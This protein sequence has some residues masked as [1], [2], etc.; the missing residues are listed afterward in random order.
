MK[1]ITDKLNVLTKREYI[2]ISLIAIFLVFISSDFILN[3]FFQEIT[4]SVL[5]VIIKAILIALLLVAIAY[6]VNIRYIYLI[7]ET[8][9]NYYSTN[10]KYKKILQKIKYDYLFYKHTKDEMFVEISD[11]IQT[12]LGYN[13]QEFIISLKHH[14]INDLTEGVFKK[15]EP[16]VKENIIVP[17]YE[18]D[19]YAKNGD[20]HR[21][22]IYET[23]IL[24]EKGEVESIDVVAHN[25]HSDNMSFLS[26][27]ESTYKKI[28]E[29][30]NSAILIIKDNKFIESNSK[31][32]EIYDCSIEEIT[33]ASPFSDRFSPQ[34]QPDGE[35]SEEKANKYIQQ[36]LDI[37]YVEFEWIHFKKN[38]KEFLSEISLTTFVYKL[39]KYLL[40]TV[41]EKNL[42]DSISQSVKNK[43]EEIIKIFENID[44]AFIIINKDREILF[45]NNKLHYNKKLDKNVK[46]INQLIEDSKFCD[47]LK[48]FMKNNN[49][50]DLLLNLVIKDVDYDI[51]FI[52]N[53][54]EEISILLKHKF[55]Q[56]IKINKNDE[57]NEIIDN[58]RVLLYKLNIDTGSY[59]Y[60]SQSAKDITGYTSEEFLDFNSEQI[61]QL[62]HPNDFN[63]ADNIIAK[64]IKNVSDVE[65]DTTI[66]YR[67]LHKLGE[68]R[69]FSDNYKIVEDKES[70]LN[71]I[72]GNV[73]DITEL[74][75]S[76]NALQESEIRF[77]KT[78]DNIQNGISIFENDKIVYV[79]DEL[80]EITGYTKEE[81]LKLNAITDLAID[82]EKEN[83]NKFLQNINADK[84]EFW[85]KTKNSNNICIQNRYSKSNI[86]NSLTAKY[87]ITTDVTDKKRLEIAL[88]EKDEVFWSMTNK[89]NEIIV[90]C[91]NNLELTFANKS[92]LDK[93]GI[94]DVV[95]E[96]TFVYDFALLKDKEKIEKL[97]KKFINGEKLNYIDFIYKNNLPARLFPSIVTNQ[98]NKTKGLRVIIVNNTNEFQVANELL[99]TKNFADS[100]NNYNKVVI[101][102]IAKGLSKPIKSIKSILKLI[103]KTNLNQEQYNFLK[104]ISIS[105]DTLTDLIS[106]INSLK[107]DGDKEKLKTNFYLT[108]FLIEVEKEFKHNIKDK[109]INFVVTK[110][111]SKD[112][113]LKANLLEIKQILLNILEVSLSQITEGQIE[114]EFLITK[115]DA[116]FIN[117]N[118]IIKN[119]GSILSDFE[120]DKL[121]NAIKNSE[122]LLNKSGKNY[123][124]C[125]TIRLI[126]N[127]YG[128]V[129]FYKGRKGK[130]I[131]NFN[132]IIETV[133]D[134]VEDIEDNESD[135]LKDIFILLVEDQPFNQMVIKTMIN[136]W[137]CSV[138]IA[139]NGIH[140][141]KKLK[142]NKYDIVLM[143]ILMPEMDGLETTKYIRDELNNVN[144]LVPIIAISGHVYEDIDVYLKNGFN[145]FISKPIT[146]KDLFNEIVTSLSKS[147]LKKIEVKS[148]PKKTCE[149]SLKVLDQLTKGNKE[150]KN[151]M[152]SIF[153]N[154]YN[155]DIT[156]LRKQIEK[157]NWG[158]V[159]FISHGLKPSFNYMKVG[160]AEDY[161]FDI[162]EFSKN[163]KNTGEIEG[164]LILLEE[165]L[166]PIINTLITEINK[167]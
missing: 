3:I 24:N 158:R 1:N 25:L 53:N 86:T 88:I 70:N 43:T 142:E 58:S 135:E 139:N 147:R 61:K 65:K 60:I 46:Y 95:K 41:R 92:G 130:N 138:D 114:L 32:L 51:K 15:V 97:L 102:E 149:F 17:P 151:K 126:K 78:V 7:K 71:Y 42:T 118:F 48:L 37:G 164:K 112:F 85:I 110:N 4:S 39:E 10:N 122:D 40:V 160:K 8:K 31:A 30:S 159:Y 87:V 107:L 154:K 144:S 96:K 111:F 80:C 113:L 47:S 124:L 125:N 49:E 82:Q 9:R 143:D 161:L 19:L 132:L 99:L 106:D 18:I 34:L 93:L 77:R 79:N 129:E 152:I 116:S 38:K 131:F 45:Y 165:E 63:K 2:L 120:V 29:A 26:E 36:A 83:I 137:D 84:L 156:E 35:T 12:I 52:K 73:H 81:L 13:K 100:V 64:L 148:E 67:F 145:G 136:N 140:A 105:S 155:E 50:S 33:M 127:Q 157:A 119:N 44:D 117:L 5:F 22:E 74:V 146:S 101:T 62:L 128:E 56:N 23:P 133:T 69:W 21:F 103:E 167:N 115:R 153:I 109:H 150:L 59:L 90:E 27:E 55:E 72:V 94:I 14:R 28:F 66:I 162:L 123:K 76:K 166:N 75:E 104:T 54:E 134:I 91:N 141:I 20:K 108:D 6:S 163:R 98:E 57:V 89:M 16:F 11:S 68:Y 121:N